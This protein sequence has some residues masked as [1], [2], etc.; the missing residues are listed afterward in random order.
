MYP[1]G[2]VFV[3]VTVKT[4]RYRVT[5]L[6]DADVVFAI[7]AKRTEGTRTVGCIHCVLCSALVVFIYFSSN[8]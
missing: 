2:G 7:E 8:V 1:T 5:K 6:G 3:F 4:E